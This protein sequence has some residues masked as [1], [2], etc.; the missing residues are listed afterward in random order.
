MYGNHRPIITGQDEGIWRRIR[1]IPFTVTIPEAE[2]RPAEEMKAEFRSEI[3]GILR[4]A[5]EGFYAW[6]HEGGLMTP[7][8]VRE[9][10]E[11]YRSE[12]DTIGAFIS[13][14]IVTSPGAVLPHKVLYSRY[15]AWCQEQG[16]AHV[17]T[18]KKLSRH[19]LESKGWPSGIDRKESREWRGFQL[20]VHEQTAI[21]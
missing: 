1:M 8:S 4:W 5:I 12:M 9:A 18:S 6:K 17:M 3:A 16:I 20:A 2:R 14:E 10:S 11:A 19:L 15:K 13:E 7:K 21:F